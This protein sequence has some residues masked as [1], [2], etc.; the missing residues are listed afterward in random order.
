[1]AVDIVA[2]SKSLIKRQAKYIKQQNK[3]RHARAQRPLVVGEECYHFI[4]KDEWKLCVI[5][6]ARDTGKS[7]DII[8]VGKTPEEENPFE[9]K[10]L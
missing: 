2:V 5:T 10:K 9:T 4:S 6:E 1:M 8:R 7:Y 3:A